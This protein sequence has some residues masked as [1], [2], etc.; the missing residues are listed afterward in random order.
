MRSQGRDCGATDNVWDAVE[1]MKRLAVE[2][3]AK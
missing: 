2:L 3:A 1:R